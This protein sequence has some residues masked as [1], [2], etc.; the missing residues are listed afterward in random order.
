MVVAFTPTYAISVYH[1]NNGELNRIN[2]VRLPAGRWFSPVSSPNKTDRHDIT[3]IL[4]KVA[5]RLQDATFR[6]CISIRI[7]STYIENDTFAILVF[8][9]NLAFLVDSVIFLA[10]TANLIFKRYFLPYTCVE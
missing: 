8:F 2:F 1:H 6:N 3:E 10:I 4:L 9:L 7:S 5:L